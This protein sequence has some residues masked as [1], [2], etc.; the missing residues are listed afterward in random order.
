M[1]VYVDTK[2]FTSKFCNSIKYFKL[3]SAKQNEKNKITKIYDKKRVK[4][5]FKFVV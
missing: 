3:L 2:L 4:K 5:K 1:Q